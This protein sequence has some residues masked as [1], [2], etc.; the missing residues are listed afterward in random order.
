MCERV[1]Y[2]CV[3]VFF[4]VCVEVIGACDKLFCD[5]RDGSYFKVIQVMSKGCVDVFLS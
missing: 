4:G 3:R 5:G 1:K 2:S